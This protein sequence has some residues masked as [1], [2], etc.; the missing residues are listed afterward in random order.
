MFSNQTIPAGSLLFCP[1]AFVTWYCY[2]HYICV[3]MWLLHPALKGCDEREEVALCLL[4]AYTAYY[5]THTDTSPW[6]GL[7]L[8]SYPHLTPLWRNAPLCLI[9][10]LSGFSHDIASALIYRYERDSGSGGVFDSISLVC[11]CYPAGRVFIYFCVSPRL[12]LSTCMASAKVKCQWNT[13][14]HRP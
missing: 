1:S 2:Y 13:A 12:P 4:R 5:T 3:C 6:G 8:F 11:C 9:V 14:S 10:T 7:I